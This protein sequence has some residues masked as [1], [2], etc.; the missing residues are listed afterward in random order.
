MKSIDQH[1]DY[2]KQLCAEYGVK[3]LFAFGSV[4][5]DELKNESD[6]DLLVDLETSDPLKYADEYFALKFKLEHLLRRQIDLLEVKE[7]NNVYLKESIDK[8]KVLIY[9]R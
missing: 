1:I 3:A 6:I 7:I 8:T 2:I 5:K 4:I 9:A